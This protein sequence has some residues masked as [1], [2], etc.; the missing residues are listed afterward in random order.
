MDRLLLYVVMAVSSNP[1]SSATFHP[2][3]PRSIRQRL[4]KS[5]VNLWTALGV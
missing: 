2:F 3:I 1:N 5:K 4:C